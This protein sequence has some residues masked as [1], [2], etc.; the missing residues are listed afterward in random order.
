MLEGIRSKLIENVFESVLECGGWWWNVLD[1]S[2]NVT[3]SGGMFRM[4]RIVVER[5]RIC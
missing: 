2:L 5:V 1:F 3:N 4:W